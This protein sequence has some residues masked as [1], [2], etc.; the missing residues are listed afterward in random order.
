MSNELQTKQNAEIVIQNGALTPRNFEGLYRLATIMS[1]S[2]MM[3]KG[4]DRPESVFVAVQMGLE[5]GLSPMQAVQNIASI[6]GRPTIWGDAMLG[7]VRSSGLLEAIKEEFSGEGEHIE[8]VCHVW[9]K[10]ED[11][12]TVG[13]FSLLDAKRAQLWGKAG[14]WTQYPLRMLQMRARAFAL[15]DKFSDV[16]K[17]LHAREEMEGVQEQHMG[18]ASVIDEADT[19][20]SRLNKLVRHAISEASE[21]EWPQE[22]D[23]VL[24]DSSGIP[25]DGRF[26]ASTRA[27]VDD[28]TWRMRRGHD[29]E[30]YA[31]WIVG[32][33]DRAQP[34]LREAA[35][36][37]MEKRIAEAGADQLDSDP[38]LADQEGDESAS[39]YADLMER[40]EDCATVVEIAAIE[41][42]ASIL[43]L[44]QKQRHHILSIAAGMRAEI[45]SR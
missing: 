34:D 41:R 20:I 24:Y 21:P 1:A 30:T 2:G 19:T 32:L 11:E 6:N 42:D 5:V 4:M 3:P 13:R 14:P 31:R 12:P 17:G 38:Q 22:L 44:S 15:R 33:K 9:R 29:P 40:L 36:Q 7:L 18:Q 10:G 43:S 23:G 35:R 27:V 37:A 26:H 16:L 45:E 39:M 25:W 8:A 28:G